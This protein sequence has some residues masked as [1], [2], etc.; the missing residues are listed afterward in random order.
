MLDFS[1]LKICLHNNDIE[2]RIKTA[3]FPKK[4]LQFLSNIKNDEHR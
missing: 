2:N 1:E 3:A 4:H